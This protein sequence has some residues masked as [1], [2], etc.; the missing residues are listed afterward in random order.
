MKT[1]SDGLYGFTGILL[2]VSVVMFA[3][4]FAIPAFADG[5]QDALSF[6]MKNI[7]SEDISLENFRGKVVLLVNVA[8]KCGLTPQY[9]DLQTMYGKYADEGLVILGFPANDFAGQEPGTDEEI[10]QFCR[11]N[12]GVTFPMFSKISVKGK[13]Q[14]PLYAFLTSDDTNPDF[15]GEISWNFTKFLI[16]RDGTVI[17]RFEPKTKPLSDEVIAAVE[18]A[19]G[20]E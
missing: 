8:S 20:A 18:A 6:T 5:E 2:A 14:H 15:G 4:V 19:L 3:A 7:K 16:G 13:N 10:E 12:Y 17:N 9:D 11:V 1:R